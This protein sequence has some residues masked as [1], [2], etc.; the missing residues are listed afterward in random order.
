MISAY[1]SIF[2]AYEERGSSVSSRK[3]CMQKVEFLVHQPEILYLSQS[4]PRNSKEMKCSLN[5]NQVALKFLPRWCNANSYI[6]LNSIFLQKSG[7]FSKNTWSKCFLFYS[8]VYKGVTPGSIPAWS[9]QCT[10]RAPIFPSSGKFQLPLCQSPF[11]IR[12]ANI[13]TRFQF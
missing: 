11:L 3:R 2:S 12:D 8:L 13:A 6:N 10:Q 5:R 1:S 9:I 7:E 4:N